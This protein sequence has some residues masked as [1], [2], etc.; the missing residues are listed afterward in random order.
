MDFVRMG[1]HHLFWSVIV[2][3]FFALRV[4][5]ALWQDPCRYGCFPWQQ[6]K[7]NRSKLMCPDH[8]ITDN[9]IEDDQR[10]CCNCRSQPIWKCSPQW[11]YRG[12][13]IEYIDRR[14][15][16][17]AAYSDTN[18]NLNI[19]K[20]FHTHGFLSKIPDNIC[21]FQNLVEID[22]SWNWISVLKNI[23]C[24]LRLDTLILKNNLIT[25]LRNDTLH[26]M[27][28]LRVLDLSNNLLVLIEPYTISDPSIGMLHILFQN[29]SLESVDITNVV[30]ENPFCVAD[31]SNN[32][33]KEIVNVVD[34]II[35]I[36]KDYGDGGFVDLSNNIFDSFPNF[37]ELGVEDLTY[38]G[39]VFS[40]GFDFRNA[41]FS[42]D[43]KMQPFLAMTEEAIRKIWRNYYN[44]TCAN[45]PSLQGQSVFDLV[46]DNQMDKFICE[47][48]WE[49]C[50]RHC[51]CFRQ[52]SQNRLVVNCSDT[53]Q[54]ALP[55]TLPFVQD[56][57]FL[58]LDFSINSITEF[59]TRDYL[60][61]TVALNI[62]DNSKLN[63]IDKKSFSD[64]RDIQNLSIRNTKMLRDIPKTLES[65]D[66]C[67]VSFGDLYLNCDCDI[68]WIAAWV[69]SPKSSNCPGNNNIYCFTDEGKK[70][71]STM[72][73]KDNL[74]CSDINWTAIVVAVVFGI[75]SLLIG[76]IALVVY[77]YRYEIYLLTR[78]ENK[79]RISG[80]EYLKFDIYVSFNENNR[81]LFSWVFTKLEP[82]LNAAGYS[83]CLACRDIPPGDVKS[84]AISEYLQESKKFLFLVDEDFLHTEDVSI[85]CLQEWRHSW[86][87]F[88]SQKLRNIAVVNYDQVRMRNISHPQ[89]RAF[90]RLGLTVDFSNR[91]RRI[92]DEIL[93][94]LKLERIRDTKMNM[95]YPPVRNFLPL[96]NLY[97]PDCRR[98]DTPKQK[99]KPQSIELDPFSNVPPCAFDFPR[100]DTPHLKFKLPPVL[101]FAKIH[102][103]NT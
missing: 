2:S 13:D 27:T 25:V 71:P 12:V 63:K 95:A 64:S 94:R 85:W 43:C 29:N 38:L 65:L 67:Q 80:N 3:V 9:L 40:F 18:T 45:P 72:W 17:L 102:P 6:G 93:E 101:K 15:D 44:I 7:H 92:F 33:I 66:P 79:D 88:K 37:E 36:S 58:D 35:D 39:K 73:T 68:R 70:L 31:F 41:N 26:G 75:S 23:N 62:D 87:I 91:K 30:I 96:G 24:L 99:F 98:C 28:E 57:E 47:I 10:S 69:H 48:K 53:Q 16:G 60:N 55:K 54:K 11:P 89:I 78:R 21:D 4:S 14:G 61:V 86:H 76:T 19:S 22:F 83:V 34:W 103:F 100:C 51:R 90:F 46:M 1:K 77:H 56:D 52:P 82:E 50:P 42:C 5:T 8:C 32:I 49:R 59:N 20:L 81:D 84:E 74:N 97:L